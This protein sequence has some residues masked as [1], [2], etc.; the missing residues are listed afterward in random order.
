MLLQIFTL[1]LFTLILKR[2]LI[3]YVTSG[4]I[5]YHVSIHKLQIVN[6]VQGQDINVCVRNATKLSRASSCINHLMTLLAR[7]HFIEFSCH[8]SFRLYI[9]NR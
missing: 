1:L 7:E 5:K 2:N 9:S 6:F 3:V 8:E 4:I